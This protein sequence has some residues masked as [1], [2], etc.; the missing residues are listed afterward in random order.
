MPTLILTLSLS[1]W[2]GVSPVV[3]YWLSRELVADCTAKSHNP[4]IHASKSLFARTKLL[5][6]QPPGK[7]Q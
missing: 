1:V 2:P 5:V 6:L 4:I 7:L 3:K